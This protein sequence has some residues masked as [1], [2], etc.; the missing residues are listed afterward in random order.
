MTA[1]AL[2]PGEEPPASAQPRNLADLLSYIARHTGPPG[3]LKA[4]RDYRGTW[5]RLGQEQR[6]RQSGT[7]VPANAGPLNSQRL[8]HQ[9]LTVMRDTSPAYFQHFMGHVESLLALEALSQPPGLAKKNAARGA[10]RR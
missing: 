10:R 9:A 6:L 8:L 1:P 4:V 5:V 2:E 7:Q 3:E